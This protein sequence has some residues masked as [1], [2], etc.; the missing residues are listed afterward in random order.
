MIEE[1][2]DLYNIYEAVRENYLPRVVL[3]EI[4]EETESI[5]SAEED[6]HGFNLEDRKT[7]EIWSEELQQTVL[8]D[9]GDQEEKALDIS[10]A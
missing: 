3:I 6:F 4:K 5:G 8:Q 1:D 10:R 2:F 7:A 9:V